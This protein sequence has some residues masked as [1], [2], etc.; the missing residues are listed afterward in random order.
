MDLANAEKWLKK[1]VGQERLVVDL[2]ARA[3][4]MVEDWSEAEPVVCFAMIYC[5]RY[6]EALR[7]S[8]DGGDWKI[9][10]YEDIC[11]DPLRSFASLYD[12]LGLS[13]TEACR[14]SIEAMCNRDG[15]DSFF[16]TTRKSREI[17]NKWKTVTSAEEQA[18]I[19]EVL[20]VF[21][22]PYY[23]DKASWEEVETQ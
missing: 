2:P 8:A 13:F 23:R 9:L 18:K 20:E 4:Q 10:F 15:S 16:G 11:E 7:Q 19:R 1:L 12:Q 21:E 3:R 6:R 17:R 5:L 14:Q 22:F